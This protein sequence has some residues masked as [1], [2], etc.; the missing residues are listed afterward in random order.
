MTNGGELVRWEARSHERIYHEVHHEEKRPVSHSLAETVPMYEALCADL[1]EVRSRYES[2]VRR[3]MG[4]SAGT[5]AEAASGAANIVFR[6]LSDTYELTSLAGRRRSTLHDLNTHLR[7]AIPEPIGAP[8]NTSG[9]TGHGRAWLSPP[10]FES[11][12]NARQSKGERARDL[13]RDYERALATLDGDERVR[14]R[15]APHTT[16]ATDRRFDGPTVPLANV[17]RAAAPP[18]QPIPRVIDGVRQWG[19]G[20]PQVAPANAAPV[21]FG[22]VGHYDEQ[23][24]D[25][26]TAGGALGNP[27]PPRD[28]ELEPLPSRRVDNDLFASDIRASPPVIGL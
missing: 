2:L 5:S 25:G 7:W 14:A 13:M 28:H 27:P 6:G 11:E 22:P 23:N 9:F 4:S 18:D 17:R 21:D 24:T 8:E 20:Q 16:F 15:T 19:A 1:Q 26:R 3:L 10:D 12:D